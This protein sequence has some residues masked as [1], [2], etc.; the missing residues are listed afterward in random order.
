MRLKVSENGRYVVTE[1]G[2]PFFWLG[3]TGWLL[4]SKLTKEEINQYL[5]DRQEKGY[6]VIQVMLL[7]TL[8]AKNVYGHPALAEKDVSKP[9]LEGTTQD[10][11]QLS[12]WDLVDYAV[13]KAAQKNMYLALVPVWGTNVKEGG[14]SAEQA[15]AY[16]TF[17]AKRYAAAPNIIWLNGGD[18]KGSD[19]IQV[20]KTIGNTL[21]QLDSNHLVTFHPRGRTSSSEWF[22]QEPWLDFNMFQSGHRRYDQDTSADETNHFGEDNWRFVLRDYQLQPIKPT[23][24]GEPSYEGIPQGLHDPKEPRWTAKD[25]RRYAYWSVFS[26]AFGFTYGNNS[27]MQF[28]NEKDTDSTAAYGATELWKDALQN[29]GAGEMRYLKELVL[30]KSFLDRVPDQS[31]LAENGEKYD[32]KV[33]TRG[34]DYA[35]IYTYNG[36]TVKVNPSKIATG[37]LKA[38]WFDPRKGVYTEI[39]EVS[40]TDGQTFEAPGEAKEGN[41]WVLVLEAI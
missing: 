16:A 11:T 37:K 30:S 20:W 29:P 24:D 34:K 8:K 40:P 14:V 36:G 23:I 12:Y 21:K 33:A 1:D 3:D 15:K 5:A 13:Q 10:S 39:G 18:L 22:H 26:G 19:S 27:I 25:I 31:L 6:N 32:Y 38:S 9:V 28:L 7:H 2:N 4:F 17:L 35:L 41:D